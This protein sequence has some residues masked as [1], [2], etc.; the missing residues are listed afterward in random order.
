MSNETNYLTTEIDLR[1][2][3]EI[4][5]GVNIHD[6]LILGNSTPLPKYVKYLE[7]KILKSNIK[8]VNELLSIA[9]K[10][11]EEEVSCEN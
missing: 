2:Q 4:E 11:D 10:E 8:K 7:E 9:S 5:T 6:D 3:Y 1:I